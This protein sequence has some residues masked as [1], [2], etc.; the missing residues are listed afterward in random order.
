MHGVIL[1]H[2]SFISSVLCEIF[3]KKDYSFRKN[4]IAEV[5]TEGKI[6]NGNPRQVILP[7]GEKKSISALT[8]LCIDLVQCI[9]DGTKKYGE[10]VDIAKLIIS[11]LIKDKSKNNQYLEIFTKDISLILYHP[12]F[13]AA[14]LFIKLLISI[15]FIV[16]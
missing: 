15:I 3:R 10:S 5:V 12:M 8:R 6:N 2:I 9:E 1:F 16:C 4:I 13:P 7:K 11:N 14:E